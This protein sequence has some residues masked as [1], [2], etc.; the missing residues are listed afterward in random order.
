MD[1]GATALLVMLNL[2]ETGRHHSIAS[3]AIELKDAL[4]VLGLRMS[5]L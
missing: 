5:F 1:E 2:A 3:F 4:P